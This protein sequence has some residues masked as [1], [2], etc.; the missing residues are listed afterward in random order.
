MSNRP[1]Q[2][3]TSVDTTEPQVKKIMETF[4]GVSKARVIEVLAKYG[5]KYFQD[6]EDALKDALLCD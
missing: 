4:P 1:P 6:K 3:R 2:K 5:A